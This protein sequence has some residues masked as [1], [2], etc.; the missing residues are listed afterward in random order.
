LEFAGGALVQHA[1]FKK[2]CP[3]TAAS[4]TAETLWPPQFE[5]ALPAGILSGEML[6][7]GNEVHIL[8]WL[9][10]DIFSATG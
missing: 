6:L 9:N 7:E 4:R 1:F 10:H 8:V 3:V 2:I 5:E